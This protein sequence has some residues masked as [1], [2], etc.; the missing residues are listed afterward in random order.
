LISDEFKRRR[1]VMWPR[2]VREP[3][4]SGLYQHA[5]GL[6]AKGAMRT[7]GFVPNTPSLRAEPLM[8]ALL[9]DLL[10][11]VET[12]TNLRL[13]PTY[14]YFRVYK[15]GDILKR[16]RDRPSCEISVSLNL[17]ICGASCWP[18]CI[19]GPLGGAE[20]PLAPGDGLLYRG[21]ECDHW[22]DRFEGDHS[23]Q[24]FL[25]YVDQ[26]GPYAAYKFDK[27]SCLNLPLEL[28]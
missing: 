9:R 28:T 19:E 17:G 10:P 14:S 20:I 22:R 3:K 24:V 16:H 26:D 13:Y 8:E 12:A 25:H 1:Y 23:V 6:A 18:L 21:R 4:L 11:D 2:V 5:L 15:R 27:R 7:D